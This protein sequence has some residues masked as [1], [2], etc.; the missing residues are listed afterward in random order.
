MRTNGELKA[1]GNGGNAAAPLLTT[2][3]VAAFLGLSPGAV[4]RRWRRCQ[5]DPRRLTFAEFC[6]RFLAAHS[7]R[8]EPQTITTIHERLSRSLATFGS[9]PLADLERRVPDIAAWT[10]TLPARF[11]VRVLGRA[12]LGAT[13]PSRGT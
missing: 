5:L 12:P 2:R 13:P 6:D 11:P 10:A 7:I 3:E 8:V 9:V 1:D 4:L